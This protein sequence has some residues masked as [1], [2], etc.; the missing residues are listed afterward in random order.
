MRK[1]RLML[2]LGALALVAAL[3]LW[4]VT[5]EPPLLRHFRQF[6]EGMALEDV[7]RALGA[8]SY[9]GKPFSWPPINKVVTIYE[10]GDD[11][12][13]VMLWFDESGALAVKDRAGKR[14]SGNSPRAKARRWWQQTFGAQ[15]PF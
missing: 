14:H 9:V 5:R 4:L 11:D 15:P 2:G 3:A 10:W 13:Y 12:A 7:Q 6:Q 8:P 1:R